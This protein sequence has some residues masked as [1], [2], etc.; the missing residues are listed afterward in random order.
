MTNPTLIALMNCNRATDLFNN[1]K[2]QSIPQ[3]I[4]DPDPQSVAELNKSL[5]AVQ[6]AVNA[7][8]AALP[9]QQQAGS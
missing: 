6:T 2:T 4:A 8:I 9:A 5:V 7:A 3:V 1:M